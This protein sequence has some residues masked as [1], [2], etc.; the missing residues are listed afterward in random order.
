MLLLI[1]MLVLNRLLMNRLLI[2]MLVVDWHVVFRFL[3]LVNLCIIPRLSI[4][5]L[6]MTIVLHIRIVHWLLRKIFLVRVMIGIIGFVIFALYGI[7][8]IC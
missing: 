6:L 2:V 3:V 1:V 8:F 5:G 4:V 7:A